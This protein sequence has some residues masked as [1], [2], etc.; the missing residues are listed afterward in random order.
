M[1]APPETGSGMHDLLLREQNQDT[2][3]SV[4]PGSAGLQGDHHR[5]FE[6]HCQERR[7]AHLPVMLPAGAWATKHFG[8]EAETTERTASRN[9]ANRRPHISGSPKE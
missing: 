9:G 3:S 1:G 4:V 5:R 2:A 6:T 7:A 8:N